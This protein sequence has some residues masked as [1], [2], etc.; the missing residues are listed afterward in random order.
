LPDGDKL[1]SKEVDAIRAKLTPE[2]AVSPR[3]SD[4]IAFTVDEWRLLKTVMRSLTFGKEVMQQWY[5]LV[6]S[7]ESRVANNT[8][9]SRDG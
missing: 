2:A 7:V 1:T 3:S 4:G 5:K 8:D 9:E 6:E